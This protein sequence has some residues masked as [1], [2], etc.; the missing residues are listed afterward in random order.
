M[1]FYSKFARSVRRNIIYGLEGSDQEP[2][3]EEVEEAASL[4]NA[5]SFIEVRCHGV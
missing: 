1:L 5:A 3:Q 2:T 4:A